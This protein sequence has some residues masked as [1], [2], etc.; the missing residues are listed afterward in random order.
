MREYLRKRRLDSAGSAQVMVEFQVLD[1]LCLI[2]PIMF[3]AVMPGS[4]LN[5]HSVV[6]RLS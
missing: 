3:S 4:A 5:G 6:L 2:F 1:A